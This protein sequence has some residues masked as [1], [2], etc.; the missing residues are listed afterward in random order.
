M[1]T[2]I[3]DEDRLLQKCTRPIIAMRKAHRRRRFGL[4][5]GSGVSRAFKFDVPDWKRLLTEIA[6]HPK[7]DGSAVDNPDS[8]P[9][10]RS[11]LLYRHFA[12]RVRS[13]IDGPSSQDMAEL[14]G[15]KPDPH[16]IERIIKGEWRGIIRDILYEH[17]PNPEQLRGQ[18]PYLGEYLDIVIKAPITITYNFDSSLEMML[19]S[20]PIVTGQRDRPYETVFDG[21]VPFRSQNGVIYHPNGYLPKNVL[22]R[23]S[24]QL[25]FSEE[26]FGDQLLDSMAGKYAS[27]AHH[28]SKNICLLIG[29]SLVDENLR[30][31]LRR[32]ATTNP[33][34]YH[35]IVEWVESEDSIAEARRKALFEYRFNV[36][37]LITLFLTDQQIAALG[38][39]IQISVDDFPDI[40]E[41]A[42]VKT[43][44]IFYL[45]GIPGIGK[46][47]I[48]RHLASLGT[49][50]EW[51]TDPLPLLAQPYSEL[52]MDDR[53]FLDDWVAKQFRTKNEGLLKEGE[54][55]FVI[56]RAPLDP[57]SFEA[58][59]D[60]SAKAA[61]YRPKILP[62]PRVDQ[63]CA[64]RVLLL[65]GDTGT[66]AARIASRQ[67]IKQPSTYLEELQDKLRNRVYSASGV[68]PMRST[69]WSIPELVR[70]VSRSIHL[71]DYQEVDLL[72]LLEK[73]EK[74]V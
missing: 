29:I 20:H 12:A 74:M 72:A 10:S 34:H 69:E 59:Q 11:D 21:S 40:A 33:G 51:P 60:I 30:H 7:V 19:A 62:T 68:Y 4:I 57:I 43:K 13:E 39:L 49:Y 35:Y 41:R 58:E 70:A 6:A 31:F 46:T 24:E 28:I 27:L 73:I 32:N 5:F 9:T 38:R 25:V 71:G 22:E 36:Y 64:G 15:K 66:V 67:T 23:P 3:T 48:L 2:S 16:M 1:A 53:Q 37:N 44:Y 14:V 18:H 8:S 61:L 42:G 50:D 56:E 52:T 55:I 45:T 47:T 54:G 17:A 65:W 63:I 26:E